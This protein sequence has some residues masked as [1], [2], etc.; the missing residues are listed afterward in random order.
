MRSRPLAASHDAKRERPRSRHPHLHHPY[1]EFP[2]HI[3]P[4]RVP[5]WVAE[6][7]EQLPERVGE[8]A[9]ELEV[10]DEVVAGPLDGVAGVIELAEDAVDVRRPD[11]GVAGVAG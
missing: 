11:G 3:L 1:L 4:L 2:L 8:A 6:S 7:R 10:G 5:P 9:L